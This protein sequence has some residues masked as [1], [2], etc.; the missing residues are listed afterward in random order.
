MRKFEELESGLFEFRLN[1]ILGSGVNIAF[2]DVGLKPNVNFEDSILE[3]VDFHGHRKKRRKDA[4]H[5][6]S[7]ITNALYIAPESK[8]SMLNI[9][10]RYFFPS[11]KYAIEAIK[12]CIDVYP[13]YKIISCNVLFNSKDCPDECELCKVLSIAK[14]I[15]IFVICPSG[16]SGTRWKKLKCPACSSDVTTVAAVL[17]PESAKE[18][19]EMNVIKRMYLK[20]TGSLAKRFGTSFSSA[21]ISGYTSL[22]LSK[23]PDLSPDEFSSLLR[24]KTWEGKAPSPDT[25]AK[26]HN[27]YSLFKEL[28]NGRS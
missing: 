24:F 28:E 12:Y 14:D 6:G 8:V 27:M 9:S 13:K 22:F 3:E 2:I 15:G 21:L 23:I 20:Y 4:W 19:N 11:R 17:S 26:I 10:D 7:M 1:N 18:L 5:G 25:K 16:N